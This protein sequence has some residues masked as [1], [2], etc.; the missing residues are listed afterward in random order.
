[1]MNCC[2]HV[3]GLNNIFDE[4]TARGEA[5]RYWKKG[6]DKHTRA[7][8]AAVQAHGVDGASLLEVG[9]GIGGVH[10]ELLKHGAARAT[11]VDISA[12]YIAAAQS[13]ADRLGILER[14]DYR[15]ADFVRIAD[16]LPAAD[17][18]IMHRV[19]C[20]YPDMPGLVTAAARHAV[21]RLVLSF[22]HGAWYIRLGQRIVNTSLWARRCGFRFYVHAPSAIRAVAAAAGLTL[23]QDTLS[24][25][26]RIAL[27]DRAGE[28][29]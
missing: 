12:A 28:G 7:L 24:W 20:C 29:T 26:W 11:D 8:V 21:R 1:M 6:L 10:A 9:G 23:V 2:T 15:H 25:P 27:F 18:V 4:R 22:P 17:V 19:V 5:E 16:D 3:Q 13:V 14:V